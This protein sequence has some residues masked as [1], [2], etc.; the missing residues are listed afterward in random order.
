MKTLLLALLLSSPIMAQTAKVIAL[1]PEDAK[2]AQEL[3]ARQKALTAE[4]E[5]FHHSVVE[6]YLTTKNE[7][8]GGNQYGGYLN[9]ITSSGITSGCIA[10][11][12]GSGQVS[13]SC[14]EP[15]AEEKAKAAKDRAEADAK[16]VWVLRGWGS[17]EY[18]YSTDWRYIVPL[19]PKT[20]GTV[21]GSWPYGGA[22]TLTSSCIING[23]CI[24]A[25]GGVPQ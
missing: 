24:Q 19:V 6:K 10:I 16:R 9:L 21:C 2:H 1:S 14:P 13:S 25:T 23:T 7:K 12:N 8:D 15:T 22:V 11:L 17:G 3:D 20:S 5:A 4:T 18:E